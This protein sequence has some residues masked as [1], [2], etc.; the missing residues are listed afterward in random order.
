M[1]TCL[2]GSRESRRSHIAN[3]QKYKAILREGTVMKFKLSDLV[4]VAEIIASIGVIVS[5][6]FVGFQLSEGNREARATTIQSTLSSEANMHYVL[7]EHAGIWD[8]VLTGAPLSDGE[9]MRRGIVLYNLMMTDSENRY[10]QF[11]SGYLDPQSWE[12]RLQSL[13][14]LVRLPIFEIW[15]STPGAMNHSADFLGLLDDMSKNTSYE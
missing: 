14:V 11:N 8:K 13:S 1:I 7:A 12:G 9:E 2:G 15:R 6:I 10:Y 3:N 5:L 4:S